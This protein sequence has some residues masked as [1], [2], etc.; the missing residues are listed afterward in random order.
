MRE[1]G[2]EPERAQPT[3]SVGTDR[4]EFG[5]RDVA[6]EKHR[7]L[8]PRVLE[9][10]ER[11]GEVPRDRVPH[12]L[13]V[14]QHAVEAVLGANHQLFEQDGVRAVRGI[15]LEPA[16]ELTVLLDPEG[17]AGPGAGGWLGDE[18]I[19]QDPGSGARLVGGGGE[20][21]PGAWDAIRL[22]DRLHALLVAAV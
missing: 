10:L 4:I 3:E 5:T 1:A 9:H 2:L 13:A 7:P 8:D 20:T 19:P 12:E 6:G 17:G 14:H 22:E 18:R 21:V 15:G 16:L 11:R